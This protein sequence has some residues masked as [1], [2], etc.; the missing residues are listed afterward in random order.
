MGE[1]RKACTIFVTKPER[2]KLIRRSSG[3]W[4][5]NINMHLEKIWCGEADLWSRIGTV[6]LLGTW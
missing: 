2:K 1:M 4:E 6:R 5:D 3:K